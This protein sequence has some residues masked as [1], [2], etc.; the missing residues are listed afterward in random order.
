[1]NLCERESENGVNEN[2][3]RSRDR[4]KKEIGTDCVVFIAVGIRI[5]IRA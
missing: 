4:G 2:S 5:L 1:M 3:L